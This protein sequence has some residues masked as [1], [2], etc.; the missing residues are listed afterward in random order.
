[1]KPDQ[2]LQESQPAASWVRTV[3]FAHLFRTDS[4]APTYRSLQ[5]GLTNA[6]QELEQAR[7]SITESNH[8]FEAAR[9]EWV[10]DEKTLE[11]DI[12]NET[13]FENNLAEDLL[14]CESDAQAHE[15]HILI[16]VPSHHPSLF[17]AE[18]AR[19]L[20]A[21]CRVEILTRGHCTR[22]GYYR[23]IKRRIYDLQLSGHDNWT[24]AENAQVKLSTSEKSSPRSDC[25]F[26]REV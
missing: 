8:A 19:S 16:S 24:T 7:T 21:G 22:G 20:L 2:A 12:V 23:S 5:S 6:E 13:A 11:D 9:E 15:K 25:G 17:F 4:R 14:T 18:S 26:R 3:S 10:A 1:M